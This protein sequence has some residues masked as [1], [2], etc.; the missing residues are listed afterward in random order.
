MIVLADQQMARTPN[1]TRCRHKLCGKAVQPLLLPTA[2]ASARPERAASWQTADMPHCL[3]ILTHNCS[4]HNK[5]RPRTQPIQRIY[6]SKATGS[7]QHTWSHT[8]IQ[9]HRPHTT[10]HHTINHAKTAQPACTDPG[11]ASGVRSAAHQTAGAAEH[12]AGT[13]HSGCRQASAQQHSGSA[14]GATLASQ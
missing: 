2:L 5:N 13:W 4:W 3:L 8:R 1:E 11:S 10:S 9:T 7:A 14:P 12:P 6:E